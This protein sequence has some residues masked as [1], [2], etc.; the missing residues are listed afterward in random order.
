MKQKGQDAQRWEESLQKEPL[1]VGQAIKEY[2][3]ED[4]HNWIENALKDITIK[5]PAIMESLKAMDNNLILTT[6][7]GTLPHEILLK[8]QSQHLREPAT[9]LRLNLQ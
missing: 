6:N 2:L 5:N 3:G 7:Y 4:F 1:L 8:I 9:A